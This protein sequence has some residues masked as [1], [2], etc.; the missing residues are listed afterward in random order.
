MAIFKKSIIIFLF[1]TFFNYCFSQDVI[2]LNDSN[3]ESLT[4]LSTG[5]TTDNYFFCIQIYI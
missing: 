3:F 1:F 2:E 4:Q 5:N